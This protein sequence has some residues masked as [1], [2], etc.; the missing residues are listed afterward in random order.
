MADQPR[1]H[2]YIPQFWLARWAGQNG[3]MV[4]YERP[5]P[6]KIV[7][8]WRHPSE[9]GW[10]KDLYR[11][12]DDDAAEEQWL[13][14]RVFQRIDSM[15]AP[16][17]NE[18]LRPRPRA[19]EPDE[20]SAWA[21]L[22]RSL[23]HRTPENLRSTKA[24]LGRIEEHLAA[25]IRENYEELRGPADPPTFAA[26]QATLHR[27][28]QERTAL[29]LLPDVIMNRRIGTFMINM[30][31]RVFAIDEGSPSLLMSDDPVARTN[32]IGNP[33]GH[34]AM[35]LS[36]SRLLVMAE[37]DDA[38]RT[39]T[40]MPLTEMARNMN[41]WTVESARRFVV[42][43]DRKQERFVRNRFGNNPKRSLT[44]NVSL[45]DDMAGDGDWLRRARERRAKATYEGRQRRPTAP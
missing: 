42:A 31:W 5:I 20:L 10:L 24:A 2:H 22:I 32:G 30:K 19:L 23:M 12:P 33:G 6:G 13:E 37:S 16:V 21:L 4:R 35:P 34:L 15:A 26:Y 18:M 45:I 17:L 9:V 8:S 29:R 25:E 41:R 40:A 1:K 38:M 14:Q 28:E 27:H 43:V 7:A 44:A 11:F 39:I 3:R 36:P